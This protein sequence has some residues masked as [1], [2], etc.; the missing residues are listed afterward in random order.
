VTVR[1]DAS[2]DV[3]EDREL[4][5]AVASEIVTELLPHLMKR[6]PRWPDYEGSSPPAA[7]EE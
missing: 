2:D 4:Y 1:S 3:E 5:R 7:E 6:L